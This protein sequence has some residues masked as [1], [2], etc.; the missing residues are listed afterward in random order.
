MGNRE[1][2]VQAL[3]EL[4]PRGRG[5]G[6]PRKLREQIVSYV[7]VRRAE[8]I[9]L[10]AIGAEIGVSWRTFCRWGRPPRSVFRRV[11]VGAAP[12]GP[13]FTVQGPRGIHIDGVDLA[14]LAE[15]LRRIG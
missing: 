1:E 14:A 8:G 2:I 4:G 15:L 13:T 3:A 10:V 6:Y 7:G 11:E 9:S 12:K 5:Q